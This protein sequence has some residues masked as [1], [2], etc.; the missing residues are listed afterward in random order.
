MELRSL[1]ERSGEV[2][3]GT[4]K[5]KIPLDRAGS[6]SVGSGGK[7]R[8]NVDAVAFAFVASAVAFAPVKGLGLGLGP[9]RDLFSGS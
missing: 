8:L 2:H 4:G 6:L 7:R 3:Q 5:K 1:L 9:F